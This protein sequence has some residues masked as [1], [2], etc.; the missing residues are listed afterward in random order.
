ME[1][2]VGRLMTVAYN[3][4]QHWRDHATEMRALSETTKDVEAAAIMLRLADVYDELA[5]R[6]EMRSNGVPPGGM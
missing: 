3:N 6:A 4:P 1:K 5:E 2:F